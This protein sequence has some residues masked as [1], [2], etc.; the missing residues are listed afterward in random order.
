MSRIP[1]LPLENMTPEQRRVY[2]VF[3]GAGNR[4]GTRA[5]GAPYQLTLHCPEFTEKWQQLGTL[6][7]HRNSLPPRLA[8]LAM[9]VTV[10]HWECQYAWRTHERSAIKKGLS[11]TVIDAIRSGQR[12]AFD[13]SGEEAIYDY[14]RELHEEHFVSDHTYQRVLDRFGVVGVIELTALIGYYVMVAMTLNAHEY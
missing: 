5:R 3:T 6:L 4:D 7:R 11:V 13:D 9:L 12:P 14:C 1:L 8:E 2:D 10:R